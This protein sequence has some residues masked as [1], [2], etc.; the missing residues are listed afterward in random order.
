MLHRCRFKFLLAVSLFVGTAGCAKEPKETVSMGTWISMITYQA[1]IHEYESDIPY[2]L[3]IQKSH[4][5]YANVQA[6]VEWKILDPSVPFEPSDPL[7]REWAAFT[8]IRLISPESVNSTYTVKDQDRSLFPSEISQAAAMGLLK[9]DRR[10]LFHPRETVDREEAEKLLEQVIGYINDRS[11]QQT[12][13]EIEMDDTAI[14]DIGVLKASDAE[15]I[16]VTDDMNVSPGDTVH[17]QDVYGNEHYSDVTAREDNRI[18]VQDSDA[19]ELIEDMDICGEE[20]IDFDQAGIWIRDDMVQKSSASIGNDPYLHAAASFAKTFTLQGYTIRLQGSG[21]S[22]YAEASKKNSDGSD[23]HASIRLSGMHV[24]YAKKPEKHAL[25]DAYFKVSYTASEE[26]GIKNSSYRKLYGDFSKLDPADFCASLKNL[27]QSRKDTVESTL[28]LCTLRIP[29]P[30]AP[31]LALNVS[32]DLYIYA[33]G[34]AQIVLS[35]K[36]EAGFEVRDGHMRLI[37]SVEK[38]RKAEI[39]ASAGCTAGIVTALAMANLNLMDIRLSAGVR[40][41][42]SAV[43]HL[44]DH[45]GRKSAVQSQAPADL[46]DEMADGNENVLVCTDL[47]GS[48]ILDMTVNSSGSAASRLGLSRTVHILNADNAP[49]FPKGLQHFENG[50]AMD[51]CTRHERF[52]PLADLQVPDSDV[53]GIDTYALTLKPSETASISITELPEGYTMQ[54]VTFVSLDPSV[55]SVDTAGNVTGIR[56]GSTR[57]IVKTSDGH[58]TGCSVLVG[59]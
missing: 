54:D 11:L 15:N 48:W 38:D 50:I 43:M 20:D 52:A 12:H 31:L 4:P 46:T 19:M 32:L 10:G 41:D 35:Q 28:T 40:A 18:T 44:Y 39:R 30:Q 2:Y 55:A 42:A 51:A 47:N 29:V 21:T 9:T 13:A 53:I 34:K 58:E 1:D 56:T 7:T 24:A 57:I 16:Y 25:K 37:R 26:L 45:N 6:A 17:W 27:M 8:L 49:L 23:V 3:N 33:S 14:R 36:N 59:A 5:A 22:V